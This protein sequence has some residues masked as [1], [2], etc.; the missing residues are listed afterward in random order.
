MLF[1]YGSIMFWVNPDERT[2][3]DQT[4]RSFPADR[5]QLLPSR[6]PLF[7][8]SR[9]S[10]GDHNVWKGTKLVAEFVSNLSSLRFTA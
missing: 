2:V 1:V 8:I 7:K 6:Q 5:V 10:S 9:Q 4:G 3:Y